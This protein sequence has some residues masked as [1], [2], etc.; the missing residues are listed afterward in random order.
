MADVIF[1][2]PHLD[3]IA[4][5]CGGYA[6]LLAS[7]G[8]RVTIATIC[9]GDTPRRPLSAVARQVHSEW[10]LGDEN[11][12]AARR[13]ED[14]AMCAALGAQPV[15][16]GFQDAI[17]RIDAF[18]APLYTRDFLG[19]HVREEDWRG[20]YL[21]VIGWLRP[22]LAAGGPVY[23][24]LAIGGHVDHVLARAAVEALIPLVDRAR[25]NF[26]EDYPY[27]QRLAEGAVVDPTFAQLTRGLSPQT[28]ALTPELIEARIAAT[29]LYPSQLPP[30]FQDPASM[31]DAIRRYVRA[32]GGERF[33]R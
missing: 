20:V 9:A 6:R 2:A 30:L 28:I 13:I 3:D 25:L 17:Y 10:G 4:L 14:N 11:P 29:A 33:W 27:A 15:H 1:V 18:D 32:V 16:G 7:Q 12:Y 5:S 21:R 31:P 8:A 26:Y 22:L 24:P 23:A 19:G